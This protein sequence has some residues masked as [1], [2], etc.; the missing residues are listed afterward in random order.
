M[1]EGARKVSVEVGVRM[2]HNDKDDT[3]SRLRNSKGHN[4]LVEVKL[5]EFGSICGCA[6]YIAGALW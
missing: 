1:G 2:S 4:K 6:R 5:Q 3:L